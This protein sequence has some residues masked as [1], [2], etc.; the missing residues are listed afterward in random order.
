[1]P[2]SCA[3]RNLRSDVLLYYLDASEVNSFKMAFAE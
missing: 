1:M 3:I 2:I